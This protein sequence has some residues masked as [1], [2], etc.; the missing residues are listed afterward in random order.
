[1]SH[2]F[3][4]PSAFPSLSCYGVPWLGY[5][6]YQIAHTLGTGSPK[7]WMELIYTRLGI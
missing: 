6:L 5:I 7:I 2:L 1:M 3:I 4:P